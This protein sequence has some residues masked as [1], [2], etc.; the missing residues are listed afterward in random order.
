MNNYNNKV[1]EKKWQKYWEENK[2]FFTDLES[3]KPKY[4]VLDMFP[5]PSGTGLHIGH[6]RGYTSSDI[7]AK[8]KKLKGFEVL[9]PIGWDSFGLPAE[10]YAI[11]N[12]KNPKSFVDENINNFRSQLKSF[13][14]SFDYS[15]EVKTSD[16]NYYKWTQWIFKKMFENRLAKKEKSYVN[17]CEEL[18]TVLANEEVLIEDGR[19]VS[20]RGKYPVTKKTMEQWIL[21]ITKYAKRLSSDLDSLNWP[22]SI[23]KLQKNWIGEK[24]GYEIT[25]KTKNYSHG[26][27]VFFESF[28]ILANASFVA[29]APENLII[30]KL[31]NPKAEEYA[32]AKRS[33]PDIT[34]LKTYKNFSSFDLKIKVVNPLNQEELPVFIV[35]FVTSKDCFLSKLGLPQ[36]NKKDQTF[37]D[38]NNIRYNEDLKPNTHTLTKKLNKKSFFLLKDW[39]FSRQRYWGEPIPIYYDTVDEK[40]KS[41][42]ESDLPLLL[43]ELDNYQGE[44]DDNICALSRNKQWISSS[45]DKHNVVRDA[46]T[47]SQWA[48][49]C[50]YF[51]AYHSS[52]R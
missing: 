33:I 29:I 23:V 45:V 16:P 31:S 35:D 30:Q 47:M 11:Q 3:S 46:N 51:H 42:N 10:Q 20:E 17:W 19:S 22:Q 48:G 37:C 36:I 5:Y 43:P 4:Y 26:I 27:E 12:N 14:F 39:V 41:Y 34:R 1:I 6:P 8:Y 40:L 25:L 15:K 32:E 7:I 44:S 38:E 13:G 50:W 49:S 52:R 28:E 24:R 2:T 21:L 9:H 18:A